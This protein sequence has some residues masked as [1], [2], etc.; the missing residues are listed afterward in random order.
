MGGIFD[1]TGVDGLKEKKIEEEGK[2]R[3]K[4]KAKSAASLYLQN[5]NKNN[6]KAYGC[7]DSDEYVENSGWSSFMVLMMNEEGGDHVLL[8][9][10]V[11]NQEGN[12]LEN[13]IA[14]VINSN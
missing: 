7:L 11:Q 13:S 6:Y 12:A 1:E 3:V 8:K 10:C 9:T 4:Q 2:E 5:Q 14:F